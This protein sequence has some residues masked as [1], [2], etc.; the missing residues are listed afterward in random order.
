LLGWQDCRQKWRGHP[1]GPLLPV[2]CTH[3]AWDGPHH[4]FQRRPH[5]P[6]EVVDAHL[7]SEHKEREIVRSLPGPVLQDAQSKLMP[8]STEVV[9][10]GI[11]RNKIFDC[12]Q[13]PIPWSAFA[14]SVAE[15][16]APA[17]GVL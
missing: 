3:K 1:R 6:G 16:P 13:H 17:F 5:K 4:F 12:G 7:N 14:H 9:F 8:D 2:P 10:R 11:L 15:I